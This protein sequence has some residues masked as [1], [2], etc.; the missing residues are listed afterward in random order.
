MKKLIALL[1]AAVMCLY[2][3][4]CGSK[5]TPNTND[6]NE[7]SGNN[8]ATNG[9]VSDT[10]NDNA[11]NGDTTTENPV[12]L[13][14]HKG[15]PYI[16]K[17]VLPDLVETIELT[18]ENWHEYIKVYSY[19]TETVEKDAF[20]EI[21]SSEKNTWYKLGAGSERYHLFNGVAI[22]LKDKAT[23]ELK[24]YE[25]DYNG[26]SISV[27]FN[28][29]GYE[30]TRIQGNLY[31]LNFPDEVFAEAAWIGLG[32][33]QGEMLIAYSGGFTLEAGTNAIFVQPNIIEYFE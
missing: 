24:V 29:E 8:S 31:F 3:C 26:Y 10:D 12:L 23:G 18:T 14:D 25:F 6:N 16:N 2:L 30:C 22:E 5:E 19:D 17:M 28:L 11:E 13:Y 1:L 27:D 20:G 9:T 15:D 7:P 32:E 21:V 33:M 4:A